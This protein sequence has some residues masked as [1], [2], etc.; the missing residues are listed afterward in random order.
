[1]NNCD[2]YNYVTQLCNGK[3]M[4]G[5]FKK[6]GL[7]ACAR[8]SKDLYGDQAKEENYHTKFGSFSI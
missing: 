3:G 1:M 8:D 5:K 7:Q 6:T 2:Q 4:H